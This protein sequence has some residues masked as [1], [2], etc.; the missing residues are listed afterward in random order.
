MS[1]I[2]GEPEINNT[3]NWP[4]YSLANY[5]SSGTLLDLCR[6]SF[7]R[8]SHSPT[9]T[10]VGQQTSNK[11]SSVIKNSTNYFQANADNK[12]TTSD[13]LTGE[14]SL[15][16]TNNINLKS[17]KI[18]QQQQQQ[19]RDK[20]ERDQKQGYQKENSAKVAANSR[21][22]KVL[23]WQLIESICHQEREQAEG[24]RL[25]APTLNW[26]PFLDHEL[27]QQ[28]LHLCFNLHKAVR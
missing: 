6:S 5:E 1:L 21:S 4:I 19:T 16:A 26:H 15:S 18:Q 13:Y 27:S 22:C 24:A 2:S 7:Q 23:W 12:L 9:T 25:A 8:Q 11:E 28:L 14:E 20:L 10:L 3:V 17:G